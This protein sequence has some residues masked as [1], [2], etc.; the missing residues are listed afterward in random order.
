MHVC[1]VNPGNYYLFST[2][3]HLAFLFSIPVGLDHLA[4]KSVRRFVGVG[5]HRLQLSLAGGRR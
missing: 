4:D 3:L 1:V 2:F 5:M